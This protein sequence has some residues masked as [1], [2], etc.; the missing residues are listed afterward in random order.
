[1]TKHKSIPE[2]HIE[3]ELLEKI[4]QGIPKTVQKRYD[5]LTEKLHEETISREEHQE[6]LG[7]VDQVELAGA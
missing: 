3:A 5:E 1:M 6:L 7:L 4:K 2:I